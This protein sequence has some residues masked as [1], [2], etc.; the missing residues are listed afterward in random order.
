M[1]S[2]IIINFVSQEAVFYRAQILAAKHSVAK[3]IINFPPIVIQAFA[4]A[5][6][7]EAEQ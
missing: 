6:F 7:M 3:S 4:S 5:A 2:Q 1:I